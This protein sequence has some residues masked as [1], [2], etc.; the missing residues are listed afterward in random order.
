V[1]GRVGDV[2]AQCSDYASCYQPLGS[3]LPPGGS[4]GQALFK[5]GDAPFEAIWA[6]VPAGTSPADPTALIGL[7]AVN[8]IEATYM[9]SD[10]APALDQGI[11]PTWTGL[12]TFDILPKSVA[13]PGDPDDLTNKLYVDSIVGGAGTVTSFSS[14]NLAPL[15]T[16]GVATPATTPALSFS[17]S[18]AAAHT[19]FGNNTGSPAAPG[20][21]QIDYSELTGTPTIPPTLSFDMSLNLSGTSVTLDNDSNTPGNSKF[22]GTNGSGTKGW[23]SLPAAPTIVRNFTF[24]AK[25]TSGIAT[26]KLAGFWTCLFAGTITGWNITADVGTITIKIWKIATGTAKPTN[27]NSINTSGISLSTGTAIRSSSL[28]DFTTLAVAAGDIFAAE[29]TAVGGGMVEFGGGLEIT[30]QL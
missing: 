8:G 10:G 29:V 11:E 15:F 27:A 2:V 20:F 17:L 23:Y 19:Y 25:R 13:V 4:P 16:T 9:R 5:L 3:G 14:G 21:H 30:Q 1:F 26:G 28:G 18:N 22:Y 7:V 12:H 24:A 6:D